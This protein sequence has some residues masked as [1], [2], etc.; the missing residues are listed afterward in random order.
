MTSEEN[1]STER[2][3]ELKEIGWA[4]L[5]KEQRKEYRALKREENLSSVGLKSESTKGYAI[6]PEPVNLGGRPSKIERFTEVLE[7]IMLDEEAGGVG[8][9]I[10]FT[11]D[12]LRFLCNEKLEE[13]ERIS[14]QTLR[15]W[16]NQSKKNKELDEKGKR[17][18]GVYKKALMKQKQN[19]MDRMVNEKHLWVKFA[20]I[21][22]RK[23][24][25]WN[26]VKRQW[27]GEDQ[28][29]PLTTLADALR[30]GKHRRKK[31]D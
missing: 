21:I 27:H 15:N 29:A 12:D 2:L 1:K 14:E 25:E 10:V 19:L 13:S 9:A 16:K 6:E 26:L 20:W 23:C 5:N 8:A 3:N 28:E 7:E 4:N 11:D 17:F 30:A 22:E 31:E 24:K 18:L